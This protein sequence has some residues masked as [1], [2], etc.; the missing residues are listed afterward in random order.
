MSAQTSPESEMSSATLRFRRDQISSGVSRF[1]RLR[2]GG[3]LHIEY[4][5]ARLLPTA[6]GAGAADIVCH[7]RFYP[8]GKER[9]GSLQFRAGAPT[10]PGLFE[11]L[12]PPETSSVEIWFE[13]REGAD[14]TGWD[15]RYGQNYRFAVTPRGL[16]VP[17]RSVELRPQAVVD[18]TRIRVVD[19]TASKAHASAGAGGAALRTGLTIRA[20]VGPSTSPL[21]AWADIHVFDAADDL[22]HTGTIPL[23][24]LET[25][26]AAGEELE[27]HAD[28]YQ[29][30]GGGSGAG[31]WFRPDAH[32][33]QYR[34]YCEVEERLYTDGVLHQFDVPADIEVRPPGAAW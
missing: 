20:H 23:Q 11:T 1:G 32:T 14:V 16:P 34:L 7:V 10:G 28:V 8:G 2:P 19:D 18:P 5:P 13:R 12:I 9:S 4:D 3:E 6:S 33:V 17:E 25:P 31:V 24:K 22:I 21:A 29:G 27:W 26:S 15:S 30:S